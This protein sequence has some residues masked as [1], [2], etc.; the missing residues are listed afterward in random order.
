MP[1]IV[2]TIECRMSS[3][4]LPGKVLMPLAGKLVLQILVERLRKVKQIDEVVLATTTNS[5]DDIIVEL[6]TKIKCPYFRG[7]EN[8][9]LKRVLEAAQKF[10]ADIIVE[11][12]GDCPFLDPE[13][14]SQAI[15]LYLANECDYVSNA[16]KGTYPK[17]F[18][19]QVY[20][21][22]LLAMAD[23]LGK[24]PPD[25]EHVS[26]YFIRNP[27]RFKLLNLAAPSSL[28]WPE[29]RLTLDEKA[30]YIVLNKIAQYFAKQG[31]NYPSCFQIIQYLKANPQ[32][33]KINLNVKQ[34]E[35][36]D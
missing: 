7:S 12:T 10:K 4:R 15:N 2:S 14:V 20:S 6:A 31:N 9:V 27:K 26:W 21:T 22:K 35:P 34:K 11:I 17:G 32:I 16:L 23:K 8:D 1:K 29:A 28:F 30:D 24:T 25:R 33:A 19:T 18:E 5:A 36:I 13:I 3:T